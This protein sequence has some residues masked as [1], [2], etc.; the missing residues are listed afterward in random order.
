MMATHEHE[1]YK[2]KAALMKKEEL[3]EQQEELDQLRKEELVVAAV[4]H[5]DLTP[6]E[7]P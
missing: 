3:V 7:L 4:A 2:C 1:E 6:V 5:L